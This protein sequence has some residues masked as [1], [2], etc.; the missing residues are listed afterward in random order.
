MDKVQSKESSKFSRTAQNADLYS[1][2]TRKK[3][4]PNY[5]FSLDSAFM[6]FPTFPC[7]F[8]GC[9]LKQAQLLASDFLPV[10]NS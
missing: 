2:G 4:Q 10:H 5:R 3:S 1:G 9:Y 7:E 6:I 8:C